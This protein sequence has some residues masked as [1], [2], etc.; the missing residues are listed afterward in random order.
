VTTT[1]ATVE[2]IDL[3]KRSVVLRGDDGIKMGRSSLPT[4]TSSK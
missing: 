3:A 2:G 4:S 1:S